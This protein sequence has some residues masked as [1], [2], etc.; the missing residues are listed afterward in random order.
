MALGTTLFSVSGTVIVS[1][2]A[3]LR[4][5][6]LSLSLDLNPVSSGVLGLVTRRIGQ[7]E[8][9]DRR[10]LAQE[11]NETNADPNSTGS[12][13][14]EEGVT[15]HRPPDI[16]SDSGSFGRSAMF[17]ENAEL[18]PTEPRHRVAGPDAGRDKQTELP[19]QLVSRQV[20]AGVV[21]SLESIQVKKANHMFGL[22]LGR[23][24]E[25]PTQ[26][27]LELAAVYQTGEG[28]VGSSM[29]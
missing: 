15:S 20:P 24:R 16:V 3:A 6:R 7:A 25:C 13:V 1:R 12:T 5:R 11:R 21:D 26:S 8:C 18:I 9:F 2:S 23:A 10:A 19:Q 28:V 17:Q 27:A 22:S 4:H 29:S 14:A